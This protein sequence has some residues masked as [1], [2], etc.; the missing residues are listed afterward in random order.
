M[1]LVVIIVVVTTMAEHMGNSINVKVLGS[2]F[3]IEV[4]GNVGSNVAG[5]NVGAINLG[6]GTV[7][8][9]SEGHGEG[10]EESDLELHVDNY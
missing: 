3:G 2:V 9:D 8:R 7:G 6:N 4:V 1:N 10:S 5:I